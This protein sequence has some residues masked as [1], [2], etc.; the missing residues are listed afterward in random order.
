MRWRWP[1]SKR[2]QVTLLEH[3]PRDGGQ[4]ALYHLEKVLHFQE[5]RLVAERGK[6]PYRKATMGDMSAAIT[7]RL[8]LLRQIGYEVPD[9]VNAVRKAIQEMKP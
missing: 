8:N 1:W 7:R 4:K 9:D 5:Q 6:S 3:A 2:P